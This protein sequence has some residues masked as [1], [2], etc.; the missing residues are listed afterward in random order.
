[1]PSDLFFNNSGAFPQFSRDQGEINFLHLTRRE[2]LRQLSMRFVRFRGNKAAARFL[3]QSMNDA[4]PFLSTDSG[5]FREVMQ[6]RVHQCSL[7]LTGPG[8]NN[9]SG[10]LVNH[11]QVVVLVNDLE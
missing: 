2:L 11:D 1:M 10:L 8:M 3:V 5:K 9:E 4:G 7:P 6:K